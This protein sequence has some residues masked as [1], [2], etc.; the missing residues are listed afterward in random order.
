MT[1]YKYETKEV[2]IPDDHEHNCTVSIW[3]GRNLTRNSVI[4]REIDPTTCYHCEHEDLYIEIPFDTID[5]FIIDLL[6]WRQEHE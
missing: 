1:S 4:L 2:R 3:Y 5:Q 6:K